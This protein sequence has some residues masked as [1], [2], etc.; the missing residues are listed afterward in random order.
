MLTF[1]VLDDALSERHEDFAKRVNAEIDRFR[2][3]NL[4]VNYT[5][6]PGGA[7]TIYAQE[8]I[9]RA[10]QMVGMQFN[11]LSSAEVEKRLKM[12]AAA[13][14]RPSNVLGPGD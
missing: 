9:V 11:D 5:P 8:P 7:L 1:F 13:L 6:I 2:D 14:A 4:V 3:A 10:G 12:R